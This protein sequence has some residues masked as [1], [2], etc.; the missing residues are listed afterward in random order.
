MLVDWRYLCLNTMLEHVGIKTLTYS[1]VLQVCVSWFF[2]RAHNIPASGWCFNFRLVL[3]ICSSYHHL[4]GGLE[5]F[6]IYWE[7]HHPNWLSYFSE[8]WLNH[9]PVVIMAAI[10]LSGRPLGP[11]PAKRVKGASHADWSCEVPWPGMMVMS[12]IPLNNLK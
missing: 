5:H 11:G 6:S 3:N 9:Q 4:V 8:G 10:R 2:L 1:S 7:C 12:Q